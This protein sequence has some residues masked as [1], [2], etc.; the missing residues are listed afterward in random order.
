MP[1]FE[2]FPG[3]E[4]RQQVAG[5]ISRKKTLAF[6][7]CRENLAII[8]AWLKDYE[9]KFLPNKNNLSLTREFKMFIYIYEDDPDWGKIDH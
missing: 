9:N 7:G 1:Y 5:E 2:R 6:H 8:R 4:I 3:S